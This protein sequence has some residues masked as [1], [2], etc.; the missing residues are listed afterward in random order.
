MDCKK[1]KK[2][3]IQVVEWAVL[4]RMMKRKREWAMSWK[5]RL[6]ELESEEWR[7]VLETTMMRLQEIRFGVRKR[8]RNQKM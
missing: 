6:E 3:G 7:K 4:E 1:V 8:K 2:Y 5:D